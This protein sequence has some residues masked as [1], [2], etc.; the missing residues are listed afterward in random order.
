M[1]GPAIRAWEMSR[2]LTEAG[3]EVHLAVPGHSERRAAP[4]EQVVISSEALKQEERWADV[5]V[6]Q[7]LITSAHPILTQTDKALVVDLYDPFV[8]ETLEMY[9]ERSLA[10]REGEHW[11][12]LV[13]LLV[14]L[15]RGDLFLCA[16]ERQRDLWLGMLLAADR[17]N[18][19]THTQDPLLRA[20]IDVAPFGIPAAPPEPTGAPAARG[21]LP[22]IDAD[23]RLAIWAGGIYN[24]FDPLTLIRAWPAVMRDL[25]EARLLFMGVKHPNQDVPLMDMAARSARLAAELGVLDQ[26]VVFNQQ[27]VPYARRQDYL[28]E[29][30]LGVSLHYQHLETRYSFRTRFLDYI[31][32]GL[33]VVASEGDAFAEWAATRGTGLVVPYED[34]EAT[35]AAVVALLGDDSRRGE[36]ATAVL[37]QRDE[38]TWERALAPL[39]RFCAEPRPA[40]DRAGGRERQGM[41][42]RDTAELTKP[43]GLLRRLDWYRRQEGLPGLTRRVV[44]RLRRQVLGRR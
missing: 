22:S 25:P 1:A 42:A 8:L 19:R 38:F 4:F 12:S 44:R 15:R 27:W 14:Q 30:D 39:V 41:L 7:G 11:H 5:L 21:A 6:V 26:G 33:P 28:L 35:A 24:W 20:L 32:A 13:T 18:P 16:N 37:A 9:S 17:I 29:A 36:C 3:N 34:V 31:W 2:V 10:E 23:S 43:E 40:A